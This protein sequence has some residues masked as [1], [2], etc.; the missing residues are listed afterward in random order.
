MS[1]DDLVDELLTLATAHPH[2]R[3]TLRPSP[4]SDLLD[5]VADELRLPVPAFARQLYERHDGGALE[6]GGRWGF[7]LFP[8]FWQW[9]PLDNVASR[10]GFAVRWAE[11]YD[12]RGFPFA[13]DGSG[14]FM[15]AEAGP[16]ERV[17]LVSEEPP[18]PAWPDGTVDGLL[19]ATCAAYRGESPDYRVKF[20]HDRMEWTASW[21]PSW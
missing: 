9:L 14:D 7:Y 21:Q 6:A 10:T 17:W 20:Q 18:T 11:Q 13:L 12:L 2:A 8:M 5:Q 15:V 1:S 19:R 16:S 4:R 3:N